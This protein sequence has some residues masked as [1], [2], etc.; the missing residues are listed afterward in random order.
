MKRNIINGAGEIER[1]WHGNQA[2]KCQCK[3]MFVSKIGKICVYCVRERNEK[4]KQK[5]NENNSIGQ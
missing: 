2:V 5:Y 4:S 3:R 1:E